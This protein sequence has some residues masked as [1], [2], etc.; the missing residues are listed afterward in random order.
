VKEDPT[1]HPREIRV[2]ELLPYPRKLAFQCA[3]CGKTARYRI[4]TIHCDMTA[5]EAWCEQGGPFE[6]VFAFS[7]Y[8]RCQKCDAA[9][10]WRYPSSTQLKLLELT[11]AAAEGDGDPYVTFGQLSLADG[12]QFH[13]ATEAEAHIRTAVDSDPRN[14]SLWIRLGNMYRNG[15]RPDLAVASYQRALEISPHDPEAHFFLAAAQLEQEKLEEAVAHL[16]QVLRHA[17]DAIHMSRELRLDMVRNTLITLIEIRPSVSME[18]PLRAGSYAAAG[19]G[20]D[21]PAAIRLDEFDFSKKEDLD[22]ACELLLW[23]PER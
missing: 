12:T 20:G 16:E 1:A 22:R 3:A 6:G 19:A 13:F 14:V 18:I 9:G 11:S 8:F 10:P 2:S 4:G 21:E 17:G 23:R 15:I 7:A 5:M